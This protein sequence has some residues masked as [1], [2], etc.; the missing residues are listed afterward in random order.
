MKN[1]KYYTIMKKH[2]MPSYNEHALNRNRILF[3]YF[4]LR[5]I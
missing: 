1:I 5:I 3:Y 4:E 2:N